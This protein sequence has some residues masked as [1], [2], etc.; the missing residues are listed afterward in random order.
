[1]EYLGSVLPVMALG[2]FTM[3]VIQHRG[4]I[5]RISWITGPIISFGRLSKPVGITFLTAFGSPSAASA[6]L[7]KLYDAKTLSRK[8]INIA[9]LLNAFPVMV[10]E[11][12]VM[13]PKLVSFLSYA[14]AILFGIMLLL[15]LSQTLVV[16]LISRIIMSKEKGDGYNNLENN[17]V[18]HG[19][20]LFFSALR[21][22]VPPIVRILVISAPVTF[23]SMLLLNAG[24]FQQ[25]TDTIQNFAG[26]FPIPGE[27]IGVIA[28]YF[29]HHVAG[30]TLAGSLFSKNALGLK[31]VILTLMTAQ[32]LAGVSVMIR[33]IHYYLGIYG[34]RLGIQIMSMSFTV[35]HGFNIL[36]IVCVYNFWG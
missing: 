31:E 10:M 25:L 22:T 6:M 34:T 28:A 32:V 19:K 3:N 14:G 12:R 15:R 8:E 26:F 13:L 4:L 17:P 16:L 30:L 2:V 9:V 20:E 21:D 24:I 18:L 29:G 35:R 33:H 27:G 5:A 7:R 1:M 36:G 11:A 23:I